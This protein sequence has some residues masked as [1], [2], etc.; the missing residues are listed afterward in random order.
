MR[1]SA[2]KAILELQDSRALRSAL[3]AR[4]RASITYQPGDLV[5]YW[6]SQKWIKGEL[7]QNGAWY[8]TAVVL[9]TVG[10]NL[11]LIHRKT[12]LRCAP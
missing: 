6:R 11:I 10:R 9:G 12:V 1:N 8:G 4:P 2:R 3:A 5:A 7:H